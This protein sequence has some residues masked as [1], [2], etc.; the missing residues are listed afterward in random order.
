VVSDWITGWLPEAREAADALG[1]IF[2]GLP[3]GAGGFAGA[4]QNVVV[5]QAELFESAQVS[6]LAGAVQ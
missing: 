2:D 5:D 4:R 1:P 3:E 6:D